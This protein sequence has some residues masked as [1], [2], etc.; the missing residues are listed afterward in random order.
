[1]DWLKRHYLTICYLQ[2]IHLI[3]KNKHWLRVK[4]WE[5]LFQANGPPKQERV[6]THFW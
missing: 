6:T 3:D 5:K 4:G 2:K 1:V